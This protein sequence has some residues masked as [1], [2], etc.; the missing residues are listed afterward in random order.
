[1]F[2]PNSVV[3]V[4]SAL[5][6]LPLSITTPLTFNPSAEV[7]VPYNLGLN[8]PSPRS[9]VDDIFTPDLTAR[10]PVIEFFGVKLSLLIITTGL[11]ST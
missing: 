11:S 8:P 6:N 10:N 1:M 7:A 9:D 2:N 4:I 3:L 5:R